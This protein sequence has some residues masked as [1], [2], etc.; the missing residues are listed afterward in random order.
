MGAP[1]KWIGTGTAR[2]IESIDTKVTAAQALPL[3]DLRDGTAGK[4]LVLREPIGV[5]GAIIPW[6][7]PVPML[8]AKLIPALLTGCTIVVKPPPESPL[9]AYVVADAI[10]EVGFP[11]GVVSIVAGDRDVGEHLV[12]HPLV[13]KIAFTG[14]GA[15]GERVGAVCGSL[16]RSVTLEL[17]GKSAAILLDDVDLDAQLPL[18]VANALPN[19]GQVCFATT[20]ILVPSTRYDE[21]VERLVA[22]V[23]RLRVGDPRDPA[24]DAGPLVASRQRERVE[25]YIASGL[26]QGARLALGGGRPKGLEKGWYVEP[27]VFVDVDNAMRIAQEEIFGPVLAVIP[28]QDEYDAVRLAN[29]SPYGLGGA[30]FTSDPA[31]GVE[32][33]ARIRTG[34][35]VINDGAPAGGGGPF[36]G[37]KRSGLGREYGREGWDTYLEVKSVSMPP[38]FEPDL[39]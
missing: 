17:G 23:A 36:G 13:D 35:C 24:T 30:V 26:E 19:T 4:V 33:A 22:A 31:R 29:D 16:V 9:S 3:R 28:Y 10:H 8:L 37:Y 32:V 14:S 21:V 34:T 6:N 5:V 12:A 7:A 39:S 15:A 25:G 11:E 18:V 38:G 1:R 20:R 27:T 2:M